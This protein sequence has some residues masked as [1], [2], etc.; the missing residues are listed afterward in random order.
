MPK[1]KKNGET[2]A[3]PFDLGTPELGRRREIRVEPL[4]P[5]LGG[6]VRGRVV[7]GCELDR[8]LGASSISHEQHEAGIRAERDFSRAGG[9]SNPLAALVGG[10]SSQRG[11][12]GAR[13]LF[14]VKK[15]SEATA[16]VMYETGRQPTRLL[17]SVVTD[18][19]RIKTPRQLSS[20]RLA[21]DALCD[22]YRGRLRPPPT[23]LL[24]VRR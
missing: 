24:A 13:F 12:P 8:L 6:A 11:V 17:I 19:G 3:S 5:Q 18:T 22:F 9:G 21:L 7:D 4:G 16:H 2:R 10:G 15:I 1:H 20:L 23:S 14:A